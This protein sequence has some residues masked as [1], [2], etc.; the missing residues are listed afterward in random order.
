MKKGYFYEISGLVQGVGFRP[1]VYNLALK[2]GLFGEVYND[3]SGVKISIYGDENDI[4]KFEFA[5]KNE[6]PNLARID[7]I[8]KHKSD[9]FF[10]DFKILPSRSAFKIAPILPDFALCKD[11]EKEFFD[12]KNPRYHYPFINCTNCGP[13]FSIIK[14]LPYDR[15]NTTM[16]SFAMCQ[17]CQSEY[18]NPLDR[19]YH[20]QPISCN[21]CGP[22]LMLK[23]KDGKILEYGENAVK[24]AAGFIKEGKILAIKGLGGFHLVCDSSN[25]D[26]IARLR[27]RKNRPQ[28]PFAVMAKN[29]Q[30]AQ[31]LAF[32]NEKESEVLCSNLKPIVILRPKI[33]AM[34]TNLA[35]QLDKIGI[36]LPNTGL[37]HLL[38]LWLDNAI[39]ATSANIS[40][41]PILYDEGSLCEK[42]GDVFDYYLDND[43][44]ICSPSDDSIAFVAQDETIFIRTSRGLNPKFIHTNFKSDKCILALGAELKNQFAIY[45]NGQV[46]LSPYVGDLKNV[47]TFERFLAQIRLFIDTYELKF[48]EM[49]CDLHPHFLNLKWAKTQ[50]VK[51]TQIQHHYAHLLSVIFENRLDFSKSYFA[52]CFDGTGYG[53][54]GHIWG[55]E[56]MSVRGREFNRLYHFDEFLLL[57]GES[58]IKNIWQ[59]AFSIIQKYDLQSEAR[60]FLAKFDERKKS[61]LSKIYAKNLGV[62]TSSLGRIFDAFA[63]II[64]DLHSLSYEGEAGM[65]LE[66]FYDKNLKISYKFEIK[67]NQICFKQAFKQ[68][69]KDDK[70][71]ATTG[72]INAIANLILELSSKQKDEILLSGG[73]FQN[74]ILLE[75]LIKAFRQKA[76]KFYINKENPSN[77]SS[78][79]L[80]QILYA[81]G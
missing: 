13:R 56:I 62:M 77:D 33:D 55:G 53:T 18:E 48:D 21:D 31:N 9:K 50:G 46:M 45:K 75:I 28:K 44:Q 20:A 71:T 11:C 76:I 26:A 81:L 68:A 51:I 63:A 64:L 38:F 2:F 69:L 3:D 27:E 79:A 12:P 36:F 72:F 8:K 65:K 59:I 70:I 19:R 37:H 40:G 34:P 80:G 30:M 58:S 39:I 5:L 32:I 66:K 43:R 61:N 25:F 57:G 7:E 22:K 17:R 24:M 42:L 49:I 74:K 60:G 14:A 4:N 41:E 54:N 47:A 16:S 23:H 15:K 10:S 78:I 1:F 67:G 35:P 73:V 6:L 29:L 52:F